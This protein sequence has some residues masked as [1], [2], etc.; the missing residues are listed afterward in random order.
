[1]LRAEFMKF[2]EDEIVTRWKNSQFSARDIEDFFAAFGSYPLEV[3][4]EAVQ[5]YRVKE[6]PI[7]PKI[8]GLRAH[9]RKNKDQN[10]YHDPEGPIVSDNEAKA[11]WLNLAG[12]S[13]F[14]RTYCEKKGWLKKEK[15]G[16][17]PVLDSQ[18]PF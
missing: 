3:L 5:N 12:T 14:A 16:S 10:Q 7:R 17:D 4:K 11:H 2:W 8:S 1:M 15:Y 9:L 6:D 13:E 18:I